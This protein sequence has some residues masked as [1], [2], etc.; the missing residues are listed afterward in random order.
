M[1][2]SMLGRGSCFI[3]L[4]L[5][6]SRVIFSSTRARSGNWLYPL[7]YHNDAGCGQQSMGIGC[8]RDKI[9]NKD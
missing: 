8:P 4:D 1:N 5:G 6:R 2:T 7:S 3:N 9:L